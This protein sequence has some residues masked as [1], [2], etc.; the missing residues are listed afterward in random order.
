MAFNLSPIY[1]SKCLGLSFLSL[2]LMFL[3]LYTL[4]LY[5]QI[6]DRSSK[7]QKMRL[8]VLLL[9]LMLGNTLGRNWRVNE[10][11][12]A[13]SMSDVHIW[14]FFTRLRHP[15]WFNQTSVKH[16]TLADSFA[17]V[18][19]VWVFENACYRLY[20][21]AVWY[22]RPFQCIQTLLKKHFQWLAYHLHDHWKKRQG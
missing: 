4:L 5:L 15:L 10:R 17:S 6:I 11:A 20:S 12:V 7:G 19:V 16:K 2:L 13:L 9:M 22:K 8:D 3:T 21:T 18:T 1:Q 14:Y